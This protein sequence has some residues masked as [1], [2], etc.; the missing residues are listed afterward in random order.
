MED[1]SKSGRRPKQV[2]HGVT[3]LYT[4]LG[5][6]ALRSI[7]ETMTTAELL[8]GEF[9]WPMFAI[10]LGVFSAMLGLIAMIH[11]GINW[12][13]V[14]LFALFLLGLAA[15]LLPLLRAFQLR[16]LSCS[17]GLGQTAIQFVAWIFLFHPGASRWFRTK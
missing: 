13:R 5:L 14:V 11:C 8:G 1:M 6:A 3:L 4:A 15:S 12:A 9:M 16:P 2:S 17:L 7:V 10:I